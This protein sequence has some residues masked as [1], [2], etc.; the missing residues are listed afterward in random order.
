M[1]SRWTVGSGSYNPASMKTLLLFLAAVGFSL[2]FAAAYDVSGA[3]PIEKL[4]EEVAKVKASKKLICI[5]YTG[6]DESCPNCADAAEAGVKA[7]RGV[8]ECVVIKEVQLKD[9]AITGKL[10]PAVNKVLSTQSRMAWV[11][12]SVFDPDMN[13]LIA[14]IGRM[15]L[16]KDKK[17]VKEFTEK[18][19]AAKAELK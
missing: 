5:V 18:I 9:A 4:D 14:T 17:A 6:S 2:P 1:L 10:T 3:K 7:V 8:A 12:F 16:Q 15:E 19:K 13:T 11:S